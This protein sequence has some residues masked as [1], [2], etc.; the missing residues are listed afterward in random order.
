MCIQSELDRVH[1][2]PN[3]AWEVF[4]FFPLFFFCWWETAGYER[5]NKWEVAR[6]RYKC[7]KGK[8]KGEREREKRVWVW[9]QRLRCDETKWIRVTVS[10]KGEVWHMLILYLLLFLTLIILLLSFF[11]FLPRQHR[12]AS[13]QSCGALVGRNQAQ[14]W[15]KMRVRM[16]HFQ[17][18]NINNTC[19]QM[20]LWLSVH[21]HTHMPFMDKKFLR[22]TSRNSSSIQQLFDRRIPPHTSSHL[23]RLVGVG[24]RDRFGWR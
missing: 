13:F 3:W 11:F 16:S 19:A 9:V 15:L 10:K 6:D 14:E 4:F 20:S 22:G 21:A 8:A 7:H 23:L 24:K 5:E 1:T 18:Q 2:K 12:A 17:L